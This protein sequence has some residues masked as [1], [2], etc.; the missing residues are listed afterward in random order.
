M[1]DGIKTKL[2]SGA[3]PKTNLQNGKISPKEIQVW[4]SQ[5][6]TNTTGN[7]N[8]Y[9]DAGMGVRG[10]TIEHTS[11]DY[12]NGKPVGE[13]HTTSDSKIAQKAGESA[14]NG[15]VDSN[16]TIVTGDAKYTKDFTVTGNAETSEI[17]KRLYGYRKC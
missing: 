13:V 14:L 7:A 12:E 8:E 9:L 4:N 5:T 15:T 17:H 11:T 1:V 2:T 10:L 3:S 16:N 6:Q